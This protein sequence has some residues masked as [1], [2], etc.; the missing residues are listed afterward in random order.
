MTI[1]VTKINEVLIPVNYHTAH[2]INHTVFFIVMCWNH[3][4]FVGKDFKLKSNTKSSPQEF[5][6]GIDCFVQTTTSPG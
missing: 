1:T 3:S 2:F 5:F 6:K 4:I